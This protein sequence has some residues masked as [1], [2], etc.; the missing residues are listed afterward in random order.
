ML[1]ACGGLLP[2][3]FGLSAFFAWL[4]G[5]PGYALPD[6]LL[7]WRGLADVSV[8]VVHHHASRKCNDGVRAAP[9]AYAALHQYRS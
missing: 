2:T 1:T 8:A 7:D 4:E 6:P 9:G 5:R 3:W